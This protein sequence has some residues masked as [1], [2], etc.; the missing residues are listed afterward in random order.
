MTTPAS[1]EASIVLKFAELRR[2]VDVGYERTSGQ[3]APARQIP[4]GGAS[5]CQAVRMARIELIGPEVVRPSSSS[6]EKPGTP[7]SL[8]KIL[9]I[10]TPATAPGRNG[11]REAG[12]ESCPEV[13]KPNP[14]HGS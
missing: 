8:P 7:E 9:S 3:H 2:S 12:S 1:P 10:T 13:F 6:K 5:S 14:G 4:G 11:G